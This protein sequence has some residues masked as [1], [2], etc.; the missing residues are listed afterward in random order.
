MSPAMT[1]SIEDHE[2]HNS[3]DDHSQCLKGVKLLHDAGVTHIPRK[4]IL[5]F[6]DRPDNAP[7]ALSKRG[8]ST[9][10]I[11][12]PIIDLAE[13]QGP[14]RST[15]ITSLS[16]ACESFGFFQVVNHGIPE[17]V[18]AD[19]MDVGGRFFDLPY[20]ARRRYL[21]S[22]MRAPVRC[23]TSFNQNKDGV[24][25]WRDF[26]KMVCDHSSP[27]ALAQWPDSP[28][29]LRNCAYSYS[30]EA[31]NLFVKLMDAILESLGL[32]DSSID[33]DEMLEGFENGSQLMVV[34]CYPP[35]PQPELTLGMPPH[36]DYG[37][38][39][40]LLQDEV[41]GLQIQHRGN[42]VTVDPIP[43]AFV[44][45]VGD[46]LEIFSNG[47][48][49]SVLHRVLANSKR[50]RSSIASLHSLPLD[51][52]ISPCETLVNRY[53]EK[54]YK[55]TSFAD[56]LEYASTREPKGKDFLESRKL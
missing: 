45:N 54:I 19:M 21:S 41:R 55:D 50:L 30:K 13:L 28:A 14:N 16:N 12:L 27:D 8:A 36:S 7:T 1:R 29:E 2:V 52:T 53:G 40:L 20:E 25:C 31:K 46:H 18:I 32:R 3:E 56:F 39:T 37:F 48:Y 23:G 6:P 11:N 10:L 43:N 9:N 49:K 4:Y 44:V 42:W 17:H 26:L 35:C 5:P 33:A 15:A 24:F 51:R 34:N 38:L 47:L 22:D